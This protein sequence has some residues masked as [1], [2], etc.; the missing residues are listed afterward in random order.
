MDSKTVL[1]QNPPVLNW[2]YWLMHVILY[3]GCQ[4]VVVVVVIVVVVVV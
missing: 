4:M 2:G 3:D 1:Q